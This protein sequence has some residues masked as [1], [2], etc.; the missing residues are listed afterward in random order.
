MTPE[1]QDS[2]VR[3]NTALQ[4]ALSRAQ[5]RARLRDELDVAIADLDVDSLAVLAEVAR[6]LVRPGDG[7]EG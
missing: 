5:A 3:H 2:V 1:E 6:R 7:N 4:G